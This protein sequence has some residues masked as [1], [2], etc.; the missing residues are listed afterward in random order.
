MR[1]NDNS[2]K[3][4]PGTWNGVCGSSCTRHTMSLK[5]DVTQTVYLT[6]YT[7]DDTGVP[8]SCFDSD[9]NLDHAMLISK[10]DDIFV[11]NQGSYAV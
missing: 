4:N 6:A 7:W 1:L 11:W 2:A 8:A 10:F 3:D 5:S 9:N